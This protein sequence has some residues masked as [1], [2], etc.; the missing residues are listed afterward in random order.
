MKIIVIGLGYYGK[1][2]A[3]RLAEV[4]H[5]IICVDNRMSNI[6]AIKDKVSAAFAL[7]ATDINS[8]SSIPV[9]EADLCLVT[10][11]EDLDASVRTIALLKKL[12]ARHIFARASDPVHRSIVDAFNVDRIIMPEDDSARDFVAQL[13]FNP[14]IRT[15]NIAKDTGV[16]KFRVPESM[17]GKTVGEAELQSRF[18]LSVICV[19]KAGHSV[20]DVGIMATELVPDNNVSDGT[21][22]EK[23]DFLVCYGSE[24][25]LLKLSR[26]VQELHI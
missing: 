14:E 24:K 8:L 5:E 2:V 1:S 11:G 15:F 7:D 12:G 17:A 26:N 10:I 3:E 13:Q 25:G 19:V 23:G 21:V 9:K 22:L 4:G 16:F 6:E 18:G 20:N